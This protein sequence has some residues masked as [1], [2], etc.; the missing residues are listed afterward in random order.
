MIELS[1]IDSDRFRI[2]RPLDRGGIGRV[3]LAY[4]EELN[5]EVALKQLRRRYADDS[6][7]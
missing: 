3:Y 6:Q 4:D 2:L 7:A 1:V 5:R